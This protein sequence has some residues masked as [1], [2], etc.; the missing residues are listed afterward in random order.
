MGTLCRALSA[1]TCMST[2]SRSS[3]WTGLLDCIG[4]VNLLVVPLCPGPCFASRFFFF[5]SRSSAPWEAAVSFILGPASFK[6][7]RLLVRVGRS[8]AFLRLDLWTLSVSCSVAGG[9]RDPFACF[10]C[11]NEPPS[12]LT[13]LS[14]SCP[15]F[16]PILSRKPHFLT[17]YFSD[18]ANAE[19]EYTPKREHRRRYHVKRWTGR[20]MC[21]FMLQQINPVAAQIRQ[22]CARIPHGCEPGGP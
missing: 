22:D 18:P 7:T 15:F 11:L 12:S 6:K 19:L 13:S 17:A 3:L 5:L 9:F 16:N 14:G 1:L 20:K 10:T 4:L 8:N 2:F 21:C